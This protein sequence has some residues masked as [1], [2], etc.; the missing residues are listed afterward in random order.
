MQAQLGLSR[1]HF[2]RQRSDSADVEI[3]FLN[4]KAGGDEY[5]AR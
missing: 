4:S 2:L 3:E 5:L 1:E